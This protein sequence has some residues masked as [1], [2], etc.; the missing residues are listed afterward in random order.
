MDLLMP[1]VGEVVGGTIREER[2]NILEERLKRFYCILIANFIHCHFFRYRL[3]IID[4][5]QW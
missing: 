4:S 1:N 5:Y 3:G 2:K